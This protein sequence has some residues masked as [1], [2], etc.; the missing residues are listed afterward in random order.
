MPT[1]NELENELDLL[2]RAEKSQLIP[3]AW[4]VNGAA[5]VIASVLAALLAL[6]FGF[7]WVLRLGA[8]LYATACGLVMVIATSRR[9]KA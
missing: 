3:W 9:R 8:L 2:T 5:S 7:G 4:A 1:L 6:S